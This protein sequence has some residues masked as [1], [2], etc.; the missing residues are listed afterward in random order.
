M[1]E[2]NHVQRNSIYDSATTISRCRD[3]VWP[4]AS[5]SSL[6]S[7]DDAL[8]PVDLGIFCFV[9]SENQRDNDEN[10]WKGSAIEGRK[11]ISIPYGRS[12]LKDIKRLHTIYVVDVY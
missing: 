6:T 9:T 12:G 5:S 11:I 7:Y 1:A 8:L 3:W 4:L 10:I 2:I